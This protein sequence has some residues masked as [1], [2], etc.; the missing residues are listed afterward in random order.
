MNAS[1]RKCTDARPCNL[2]NCYSCRR[3][4]IDQTALAM[5]DS[6]IEQDMVERY[7]SNAINALALEI[8]ATPPKAPKPVAPKVIANAKEIVAQLATATTRERALVILGVDKPTVPVLRQV[9]KL[10]G[11][12]AQS[13]LHKDELVE[14]LIHFTVGMR[15]AHAAV[16][17]AN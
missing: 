11:L 16:L 6:G 3:R 8:Q 13:K 10:L 5:L 12:G 9:S 7:R 4:L 15:L 17:Q 2:I 1:T 14:S